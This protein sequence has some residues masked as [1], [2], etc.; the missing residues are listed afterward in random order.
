MVSGQ[1]SSHTAVASYPV[2]QAG[3][4]TF[5]SLLAALNEGREGL[6]YA[7]M[8]Q[9]VSFLGWEEGFIC[10]SWLPPESPPPPS[11]SSSLENFLTLWI[12]K[13]CRI[14]WREKNQEGPPSWQAQQDKEKENLYAQALAR[15]FMQ[16]ASAI[17]PG[18]KIEEV[19]IL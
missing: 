10:L 18:L 19:K 7:H 6:L 4:R 17:F 5:D 1:T 14:L 12:G 16:K 13:K 3:E 11:F 2:D 9:D 8:T 15:P